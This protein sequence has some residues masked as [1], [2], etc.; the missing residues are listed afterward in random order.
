M[1][2]EP[3]PRQRESVARFPKNFE[4]P[5]ADEPFSV[6]TAGDVPPPVDLRTLDNERNLGVHY[7]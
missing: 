2:V 5:R 1:N 4:Q 6:L 3:A 7:S